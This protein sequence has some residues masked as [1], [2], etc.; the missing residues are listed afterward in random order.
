MH[1]RALAS[2]VA[3]GLALSACSHAPTPVVPEPDLF[4]Y[5]ALGDSYAAAPGVPE[6]TGEDGC[7]RSTDNYP[8]QLAARGTDVELVDESCSGATTGDVVDK[9]LP[10]VTRDTDLVTLGIGGNDYDLFGGVLYACLSGTPCGAKTAA[11]VGSLIPKIER[12]IGQVLDEIAEDAPDAEVVVVGYPDLV[13]ESGTCPQLPLDPADYPLVDDATAQLN[14]ALE[15]QATERSL[16]FL[17]LAAPSQGHDIC[18]EDPWVNGSEMV[19][20]DA[21]PYHPFVTEQ[22]AVADLLAEATESS[23]F[24]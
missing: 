18:S 14:G 6:T 10:S 7:F 15:R 21:I 3:L 16:T 1:R 24:R 17:D 2:I 19:P 20:G 23:V 12:N 13:P 9:Q 4:R 8:Q 22:T 11:K 5:V